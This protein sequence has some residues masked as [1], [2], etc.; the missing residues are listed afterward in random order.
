MRAPA[1]MTIH[2]ISSKHVSRCGKP[3][4][5]LSVQLR[6]A[7]RGVQMAK[8]HYKQLA[9]LL[10]PDKGGSATG[11]VHL[12]GLWDMLQTADKKTAAAQAE[13][14][15]ARRSAQH[16]FTDLNAN[17]NTFNAR[18]AAQTS[19]VQAQWARWHNEQLA[20]AGAEAARRH[21]SELESARHR[22]QQLKELEELKSAKRKRVDAVNEDPLR[23]Y[24]AESSFKEWGAKLSVERQAQRRMAKEWRAGAPPLDEQIIIPTPPTLKRLHLEQKC[25]PELAAREDI[26]ASAE[27]EVKGKRDKHDAKQTE[28]DSREADVEAREA[29]VEARE[30]EV[31]HDLQLAVD[32]EIWQAE[33]DVQRVQTKEQK[34]EN[35][36]EKAELAE[37]SV[38]LGEREAQLRDCEESC[39][40]LVEDHTVVSR[41]VSYLQ[42]Q[43]AVLEREIEQLVQHRA[44]LAATFHRLPAKVNQ[45]MLVES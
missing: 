40:A 5:V 35:E 9:L 23:D 18:L 7:L 27:Y 2:T 30:A 38:E 15:A 12:N 45:V 1:C 33:L 17:V 32:V 11:F 4:S 20:A 43:K 24:F 41:D 25:T 26:V 22:I 44:A 39:A 10:H 29:D 36:T 3:L 6:C 14:L 21:S 28:L 16:A 42:Q 37:K 31:E 19:A 13:T 8:H 34:M